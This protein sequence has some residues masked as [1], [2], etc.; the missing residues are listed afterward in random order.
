[1]K[2]V[3]DQDEWPENSDWKILFDKAMKIA[4]EAHAGQRD[5]YDQPYI[6]HPIRVMQGVKHPLGKICAILHDV[7]EDSDWTLEL[8]KKEGF[9]AMVLEALDC[10]TKREGE[11]YQNYVRRAAQNPIARQVKLADLKDNMTLQR[12]DSLNPGDFKRLQKYHEAWK[13]IENLDKN[14][15]PAK[16]DNAP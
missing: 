5:R 9:P 14:Q 15:Q 3:H 12:I 7:V 4:V 10:L 2:K 13:F 1:M 8:L 6:L 11:E 16:E